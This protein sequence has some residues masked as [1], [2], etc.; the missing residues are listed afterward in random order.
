MK[1]CREI[2]EFDRI[3]YDSVDNLFLINGKTALEVTPVIEYKILNAIEKAET[4][5]FSQEE[6]LY[7]VSGIIWDSHPRMY[8]I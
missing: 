2:S 5:G 3:F 4:A 1:F 6:I 7:V 8:D